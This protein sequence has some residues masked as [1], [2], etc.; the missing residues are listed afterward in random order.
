[1]I[2]VSSK[3]SDD[4]TSK[5]LKKMMLG[6]PFNRLERF[7][8]EGVRALSGATPVHSGLAASSWEYEIRKTKGRYSLSWHNTNVESGIPVVILI[9]Y[10]HGTRG[11]SWVQGRDFINPVMR[12]LFD[13]IADEVWREVTNG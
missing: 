10:G 5:F 6:E 3:S 9:Q 4:P 7:G 13:R 12:P 8:E 2:T 11:G 1:M